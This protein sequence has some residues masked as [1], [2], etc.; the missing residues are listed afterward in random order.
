MW[1]LY[2]KN[3]KLIIKYLKLIIN[4]NYKDNKSD[5]LT[6]AWSFFFAKKWHVKI[7]KYNKF[8]YLGNRL[9]YKYLIL[10][11]LDFIIFLNFKT[12][13]ASINFGSLKV[14]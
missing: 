8:F 7:F 13:K 4:E 5:F 14:I 9:K 1:V 12:Y 2:S 6:L 11:G 10:N 3:I